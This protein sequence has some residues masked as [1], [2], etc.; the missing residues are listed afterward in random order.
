MIFFQLKYFYRIK[1]LK[2]VVTK[3]MLQIWKSK[4]VALKKDRFFLNSLNNICGLG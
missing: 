3:L 4:Y 1:E 2:N